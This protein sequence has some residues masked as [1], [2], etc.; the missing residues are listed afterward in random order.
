MRISTSTI[1]EQ[2]SAKISDLQSSLVNTQQQLSTG[3]RILTPSDDPV[4][5]AQVLNVTQAQSVNTQFATNRQTASS[6]LNTVEGALSS[7]TTMLQDL[8]TLVISAGNPGMSDADRGY[9]A[10]EIRGRFDDLMGLAN[11]TDGTGNYVFGGY[12]TATQPFVKTSTVVAGVTVTGAQYMGDQGQRQLQVDNTRQLDIS[13]S[14]QGIFQTGT[15]DIFKALD[16]L[17]TLLEK[18]G[19]TTLLVTPPNTVNDL[20]VGL[21]KANG[22]I[23]ATMDKVLTARASVGSKLKELDSLDSYGA[24]RDIQ[25][26]QSLS[27]LQDLDYAK[28][29]S[30]LTQQ[31]TTLQA[32]Q[33]SFVKISNLSLFNYIN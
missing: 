26:S 11:S 29:I 22:D 5:A 8:K 33:Q 31:Q 7:T 21:Q 4:A 23:T 3:K 14:G 13:E 9:I 1:Y 32:A 6:S 19:S 25:Y 16:D 24:D 27:N 18:P 15:Q 28:A 12:H 30:Q 20:T 10:T 17:A 2:G